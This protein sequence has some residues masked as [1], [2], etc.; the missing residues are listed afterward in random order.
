MLPRC[1]ARNGREVNEIVMKKAMKWIGV[2]LGVLMVILGL[3]GTFHPV[4]FFS[5]L[6][7]LIGL[8]VMFAGFDGLGA[9]WAGR[10]T[11]T[12]SGWDLL[13]AILSVAFGILLISNLWLRVLTDE[14]LLA[15]FGVWI[16]LSGILRIV[17]AVKLKPKAWGLLVVI[18]VALII[19]AIVSLAHPLATAL[20]I[21]LCVALNFV[22]QG[23]N[24]IFGALAGG[25]APEEPEEPGQQA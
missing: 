3:Y 20:S 22:F 7:W 1:Q 19:L 4:V 6:G 15:L 2:I 8:A 14:V 25:D 12:T 17:G 9:W 13:L 18:G 10:K 23:F 24:M 5:S 11:K 16:A 21:G